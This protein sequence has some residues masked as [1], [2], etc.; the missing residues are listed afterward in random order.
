MRNMITC[1]MNPMKI[2]IQITRYNILAAECIV[3]EHMQDKTWA[4]YAALKY[5]L[6]LPIGGACMQR[7]DLPRMWNVPVGSQIV[8]KKS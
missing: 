4:A 5:K 7:A 2:R 1:D 8:E 6:G 3:E